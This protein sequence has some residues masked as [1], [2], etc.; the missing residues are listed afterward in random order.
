MK[1]SWKINFNKIANV[2]LDSYVRK[3]I[4]ERKNNYKI[5]S[6]QVIRKNQILLYHQND[7]SK[8]HKRDNLLIPQT[9][10]GGRE[11]IRRKQ[12]HWNV[13]IGPTNHSQIKLHKNKYSI[14]SALSSFATKKLIKYLEWSGILNCIVWCNNCIRP[15][16]S[17]VT[18]RTF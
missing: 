1:K 3:R 15:P 7:Q 17:K 5:L 4:T 18:M 11:H 12:L 8:T 16:P 10:A 14:F 2:T 9:R 13:W 6:Y